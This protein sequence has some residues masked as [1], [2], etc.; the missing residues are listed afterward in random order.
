MFRVL[1]ET[2]DHFAEREQ[3]PRGEVRDIVVDEEGTVWVATYGGGVGRMRGGQVARLTVQEGLPDN[4]VSRMIVDGRDRMW[5]STN[6]GLAIVDRGR[7][8]AVTEGR[9]PTLEPV[10]LGTERG[11]PEGQLRQP[12]RCCRCRWASLVR[13]HR[14]RGRRGQ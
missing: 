3:V 14:W 2:V 4:S 8:L 1:G 10:V 7:M 11:V 9:A 6:R 12:G 13:H 5:I